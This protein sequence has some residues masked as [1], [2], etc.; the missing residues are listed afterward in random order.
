VDTVVVDKTGTLT[1]GRPAV[2]EVLWMQE[3]TEAR[4]AALY[5]LEGRSGHPLAAALLAHLEAHA[6][7][8]PAVE[9][10]ENLPGRGVQ[11][12][13]AGQRWRAGRLP[14]LEAEGVA[15]PPAAW[16]AAADWQ[17]DAATVVAFSENDTLLALWA[18]ADVLKPTSEAAVQ[19]LHDAGIEVH[20]LSG[21][22]LQTAQAVA[23]QTG[24]RHVQAGVLPAEKGERVR[25]L[26][27]EGRTVAMV[28]DGINDAEAL[29]E[30]DLGVAVGQGADLAL[31]VAGL[32]LL[33]GDLRLLPEALA[34]SKRTV[35]VLRQNL[36]W[37][38]AYNVVGIPLAAGVLYPINGFLLNPMMA[39]AAMALSSVSVVLNSLRLKQ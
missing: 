14:W 39:G 10:F 6:A 35:A 9:G 2:R 4:C 24:I 37:A 8:A 12:R 18:V 20:L 1:V 3:A 31:D 17:N 22:N 27:A 33:S 7:A 25:Q 29:A 30:A 5:A 36:F 11:G 13:A 32:V 15:V 19:R 34:L 38:F 21:D 26:K 23:R 16:A 28:G